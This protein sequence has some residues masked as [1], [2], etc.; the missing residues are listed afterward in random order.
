MANYGLNAPAPGSSSGMRPFASLFI[1]RNPLTNACCSWMP[2][3]IYETWLKSEGIISKR[4]EATEKIG[5]HVSS[6]NVKIPPVHPG[7]IL[8]D[9][10]NERRITLNKLAR[11]I[12]V[13]MNR[14]SAVVN[15]K[16]SI[17]ADTALRLGRYFGT[18]AQFWLNLQMGYELRLAEQNKGREIERDVPP[19]GDHRGKTITPRDVNFNSG[20]RDGRDSRTG[21]GRQRT[22]TSP[23]QLQR[24]LHSP[25]IVNLVGD[26]AISF[27]PLAASTAG[28]VSAATAADCLRK[29]RRFAARRCL[30]TY[31]EVTHRRLVARPYPVHR[32][33]SVRVCETRQ[34]E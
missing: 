34:G 30:D 15:A 28:P 18:S 14:I 33:S 29:A 8:L 4:S 25:R 13:P 16:R 1:L 31:S 27:A 9:E 20:P 21:A 19:G 12:R 24:H 22:P 3:S 17:T 32:D 2:H 6:R 10:L 7:Q 23:V 11:E 26:H 5:D